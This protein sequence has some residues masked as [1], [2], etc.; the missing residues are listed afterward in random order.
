M[1]YYSYYLLLFVENEDVG[2]SL[3]E[4]EAKVDKLQKKQNYPCNTIG[5]V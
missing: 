2:K 5:T 3:Y 1:Q 4:T